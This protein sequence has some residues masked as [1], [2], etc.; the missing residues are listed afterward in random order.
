[1]SADETPKKRKVG[2]GGN[3]DGTT[4][5]LAAI[6]AEMKDMKGRLSRMDEL[7]NEVDGMKSRLS[8]MDELEK[9][10][11]IQQENMGKLGNKCKSLEGKCDSSE[12][13]IQ[14]LIK[15][16]KWEYSAPSIPRSYWI[17]HDHDLDE[18]YIDGMEYLLHQMKESTIELRSGTCNIR[19]H[20]LLSGGFEDTEIVL[21]HDDDWTML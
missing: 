21:R 8:H 3:A 9:K 13:S 19:K 14:I 1:M 16:Q 5:S 11:Q 2:D 18:H 7:E 4:S 12:R 20:I 17:D 6:W 15:E 10:C